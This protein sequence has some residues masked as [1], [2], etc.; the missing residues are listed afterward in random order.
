[1]A[2]NHHN[3]LSSISSLFLGRL[4]LKPS[5]IGMLP[6]PRVFNRF[7]EIG[8]PKRSWIPLGTKH[9]I[10]PFPK[11]SLG[12]SMS[13]I[14]CQILQTI[15]V[16]AHVIQFLRRPFAKRHLIK[17]IERGKQQS[18]GWGIIHIPISG[19]WISSRPRIGNIVSNIKKLGRSNGASSRANPGGVPSYTFAMYQ[20][21]G[22][23]KPIS[24]PKKSAICTYPFVVIRNTPV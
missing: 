24:A 22:R 8:S 5:R 20:P 16:L 21:N 3:R 2:E 19:F 17:L 9:V 15:L 4:I 11:S 7:E 18:L 14:S 6:R 10:H 12:H 23:D 1:M 13:R